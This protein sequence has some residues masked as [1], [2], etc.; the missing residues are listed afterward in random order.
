MNTSRFSV[1]R[2]ILGT[3]LALAFMVSQA[4]FATEKDE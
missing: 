1:Y 4:V 3:L 2:M